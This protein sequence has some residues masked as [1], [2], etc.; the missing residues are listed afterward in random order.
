MG[1]T[2]TSLFTKQ[3]NYCNG[4]GYEPN[5]QSTYCKACDGYTYMSVFKLPYC[6]RPEQYAHTPRYRTDIFENQEI[7]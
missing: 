1:Q 4:T 7:R 2:F 5:Y 6:I 3:C